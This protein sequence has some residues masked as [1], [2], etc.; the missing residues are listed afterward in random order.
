MNKKIIIFI[1]ICVLGITLAA[2]SLHQAAA[3]NTPADW[4]GSWQMGPSLDTTILGCV[5]G[6]GLA[7]ITGIYYPEQ[8]R[9]YFLGG[10]C[11][12][13]TTTTGSVFYFDPV[14]RTY[15]TTGAVMQTPV[16]NYQVVRI[17]DD[18]TGHG[19]GLYIVGGRTTTGGQTNAL[20]VYYPND[21]T[22]ATIGTDPFPPAVPYSPGGVVANNDLMYVF[23]GFDGTNMYANTY[24]YDPAAAAGA[25]WTLSPCTLPTPR[26]YIG[27]VSLG[28][29]IYAIGGDTVPVLTPINDTVVFDT[30]N[31]AACWQ[32]NLM[33]D[34]PSA[35]G[36][37]PAVYVDENYIGGG[38]FLVGGLWPAPGPDRWVFRYDV[39]GDFWEMFPDL[40]IPAPATGR[41]NEAA[42]YI[43]STSGGTGDGIPG[44]WAFGGYDGSGTNAMTD[45]SEFFA[46]PA[47]PILLLPDMMELSG[48]AGSTVTDPFTLVNQQLME[49]SF[50][51]SYTSD[52]TWTVTLPASVGPIPSGGQSSFDMT[53]DI[54][55]GL[56]CGVTGSFTVV[57]TSQAD[58]E[59]TAS[60]TVTVE[61]MCGV[62]GK[63]TDVDT[64]LPIENAYV[65][66]QDSV[67]GL[68][69]YYDG[70]T[71]AEGDY[72]M[73]GVAPGDY[74]FG[75]DAI[76]H[77]PS[78]YPAGWP[79][80]AI[81]FTLSTHAVNIDVALV[82]SDVHWNPYDFTVN[83][84]PGTTTQRTLQ[85]TNW[86]SGPYSAIINLVDG[87]QVLPPNAGT[88]A[89][90]GLPRL[91]E[92]ILADINT[93]PSGTTDFVV[94]LNGQANL[95]AASA[96]TNW[97]E[98]G[99]AVY[100]ALTQYANTHQVSLRNYLDSQGVSYTPLY[101]INGVIVHS[102]NTALV[103]SLAARGDVA[104]LV[105]NH[106]IAVEKTSPLEQ[107]FTVAQAP[108][109][110]EWNITKIGAPSVWA[111]YGDTGAG[112]VVANI[113]TGVQ[114]D[115]PALVNQYRGNQ[116][117]GNFDHNYNWYDPYFQC[118]SGGTIPCDPGAH[119][120]HTM[121]TMVGDDG[122]ANQIGVAPG[123][124]WIAC[125]GGDAVSGYLLTNELLTCAQWILAPFD[126]TGANPDPDLR[127]NVV[128]NSWGGG[129][130]DY[131]YTGAI[132][133]WRAAGIF[134]AFSAG[135]SGPGCST[136]GSP[137]DNWESVATGASDIND[138]LAAF[139][140][141]GPAYLTGFLKPQVT[142][143]GVNIR[144]SVPG[145][146]Y[147]GGWNGTSMASPHTAGS[148]ALL[149][150][151]VPALAG[152]ID[153]TLW[154][155]E[156][157]ADPL[158]TQGSNCGGDYVTGPNND[159]G[160]GRLNVYE[161]VTMALNEQIVPS[162]V[163]IDEQGVMM[164]DL[165]YATRKLTFTAP[166]DLGSYD[167]TLIMVGDDPYNPDIRIPITLNVVAEITNKLFLP[168]TAK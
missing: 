165:S 158:A 136:A 64:G 95:N 35:D 23:G 37:A 109:V 147:Q 117:G 148:V 20:Q 38:I 53:V 154:V 139:S 73:M 63:V 121:G 51:I 80:G 100:N 48:L 47:T 122:G 145:S 45:T 28:N 163:T 135:N 43:P 79:D 6:N 61:V 92:Q 84:L 83:M 91:D 126:L 103:N 24:I 65:W 108:D 97:S 1:T 76:F 141:R 4:S 59:V 133:A 146:G 157:T 72:L 106:R 77:Q 168:Y 101:I 85:I 144:S 153:E 156:Q 90:P 94:V 160:Y 9:V 12:N 96:N 30:A 44:L 60:A 127:P 16:S 104:Q 142:A 118:P 112:M 137:G 11:E 129:H 114:Y 162:W 2:F 52:V 86:G 125:K 87:S 10:R 134:P 161:A 50:D 17:D 138:N 14:T 99:W 82:A 151:A 75:A 166:M 140:S 40:V 3:G 22:V 123:A 39:A 115:H 56:D 54:P 116:G 105:A 13:D 41:R 111:D 78:F 67:D 27:A 89:V 29:L 81:T 46:N 74:Y 58:P 18:G 8:D 42:V 19:P 113:D 152:Q 110:I 66:I 107:Q 150:S 120:T 132:S 124:K 159:W 102:G 93:S 70:Y 25:R 130:N 34:L 164:D 62:T 119:G 155:L 32:D 71:N 33:A 15:A 149:W 49:D 26:S 69:V 131:W 55:V 7:R 167:A 98:R 68:G 31:P 143:P 88:M 128:N 21:N 36:D 57:A 5:A